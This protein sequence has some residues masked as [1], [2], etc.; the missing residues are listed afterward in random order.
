MIVEASDAD[1]RVDVSFRDPQGVERQRIND[2]RV[3]AEAG[4]VLLNQ[5]AVWA[6]QAPSTSM[7]ALAV[8]DAGG[9]RLLGEYRFEHA[10]T[11]PG[12]PGREW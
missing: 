9:E 7:T 3:R 12:P 8:D 5:S 6:K 10:R 11:I 1:L 4:I 2:I